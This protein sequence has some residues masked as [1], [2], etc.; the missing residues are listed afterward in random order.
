MASKYA[1]V[2][3]KSLRLLCYEYSVLAYTYSAID[4]MPVIS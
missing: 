3:E 1:R 4:Q 2:H